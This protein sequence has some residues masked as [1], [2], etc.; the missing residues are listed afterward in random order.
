MK[1]KWHHLTPQNAQRVVVAWRDIHEISAWNDDDTTVG[2]VHLDTI[3]WMVYE[4]PDPDEPESSL[5]VIAKTYDY[6]DR[7]WADYTVFPR[8]VVKKV[9]REVP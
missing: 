8:T 3:G 2:P 4:G 9:D 6:N 1:E 7:R 5:V